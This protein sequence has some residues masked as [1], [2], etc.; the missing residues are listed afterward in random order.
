MS[1]APDRNHDSLPDSDGPPGLGPGR[2]PAAAAGV[3]SE[4]RQ[5]G[6][7]RHW[8]TRARP[9]GMLVEI[10]GNGVAAPLQPSESIMAVRDFGPA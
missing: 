3:E 8:A 5:V 2:A 4:S 9:G 7:G 6:R 1:A 10:F